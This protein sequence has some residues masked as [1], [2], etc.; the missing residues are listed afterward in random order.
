MSNSRLKLIYKIND[1]VFTIINNLDLKFIILI[2]FEIVGLSKI[3]C[4]VY[5]HNM[6]NL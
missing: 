6:S 1:T 4:R 5:Q 3:R 2:N